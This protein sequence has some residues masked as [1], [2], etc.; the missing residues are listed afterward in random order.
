MEV[1]V[2]SDAMLYGSVHR[3]KMTLDVLDPFGV[4]HLALLNTV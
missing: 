1:A 3:I 4:I 2:N